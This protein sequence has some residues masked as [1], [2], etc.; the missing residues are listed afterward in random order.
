MPSI[1]VTSAPSA[2]TAN[3]RHDRTAS[4]ST[5]TVH[6]PHTPCSQPRCV[7]VSRHCSRRKSAS[8][9]R[10]STVACR[11]WPF[12]VKRAPACHPSI[13]SSAG[14]GP[15]S[16]HHLRADPRAVGGRAVQVVRNRREP[17]HRQSAD[18]LGLDVGDGSPGQL[19][20]GRRW[21][22][23]GSSPGRSGRSRTAR[24]GR[25]RRA[26]TPTVGAGD[27]EVA[28][29]AG[30]LLARRSRSGRPR[31]GSDTPTSS[32]SGAI[33]VLQR[34]SKKSRGGDVSPPLRSETTSIVASS[35]SAT[36]G[37]SAAGSAWAIEPPS[38]PRLR[39]WK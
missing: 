19:G 20:L 14:L 33:A 6:A 27:G 11:V 28:V 25:R 12:T 29:A 23:R 37:Y 4:P 15:R 13:A 16:R 17:G 8:V 30:E 22:A 7:P 10:G 21:P 3:I 39:I 32:S 2:W 36:A 38:V 24:C 5:R 1:V 34:P 18:L 26:R 31:P 9:R 35:A